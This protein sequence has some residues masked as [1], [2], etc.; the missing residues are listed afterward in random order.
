MVYF[1]SFFSVLLLLIL[2]L[3]LP[4][5]LSLPSLLL[6]YYYHHKKRRHNEPLQNG[7]GFRGHSDRIQFISTYRNEAHAVF[8]VLMLKRSMLKIK[9]FDSTFNT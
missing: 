5:S 6:V 9:V 7:R 3:L 2:L 1:F 8:Q 4:S